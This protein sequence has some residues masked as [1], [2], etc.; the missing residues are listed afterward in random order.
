MTYYILLES[1]L[2]GKITTSNKIPGNVDNIMK[3]VCV[4][5]Q[6]FFKF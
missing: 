6:D 5:I 4:C 1:I 2:T 3:N